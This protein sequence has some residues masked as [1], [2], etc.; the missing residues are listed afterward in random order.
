MIKVEFKKPFSL[1]M[2]EKLTKYVECKSL[3]A[4]NLLIGRR[5][6]TQLMPLDDL[7]TKSCYND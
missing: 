5:F 4:Q 2:G 3:Q 7:M 6:T 1:R